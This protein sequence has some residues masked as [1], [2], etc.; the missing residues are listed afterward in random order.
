MKFK[1]RA[2]GLDQRGSIVLISAMGLLSLLATCGLAIDLGHLYVV[3]SE[4][5][6]AADAGAMAGA[7]ALFPY[8]LSSA[9]MPLAPNCSAALAQG[10][11][12]S[13]AN[14]VDG[15]GAVVA[16]I[17]SGLWD[18]SSEQFVPGCSASP[19]SNAISLTTRRDNV[20]LTVMGALG[21][22]PVSL[23]ATCI[24][25]M[26]WV[27]KLEQGAGSVLM[28]GKNYA[29]TGDVY[30]YLNPDPLDGGGWY[31]K[32]PQTPNAST[33]KGYLNAPDTVPAIKIGDT[34]NMNNGALT[35]VLS[36][37]ADNWI[38]KTIL[39]PVVDTQ[40]Y[41]QSGP[42]IGFT[43][44]TITEVNTKGH[45]YIRGKALPLGDVSEK[46]SDPGGEKFGLL[47]AP[48]VVK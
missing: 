23:Q 9:A 10:R 39:M 33:L 42:V 32:S 25:V 37:L 46:M 47:S 43:A 31:T 29:Q 17:Q 18:C 27:G 13:Q 20:S 8:P 48:R 4:L 45:K 19:F 34:I 35:S 7:R 2:K 22:G 36:D 5:H 21:L 16:D 24:A 41:N 38:G 40:K 11:D 44:F 30:I 3:K 15:S 12:I 6:R 26:D 14:L 1:R 28:I